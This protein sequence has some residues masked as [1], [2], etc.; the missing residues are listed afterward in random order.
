[1]PKTVAARGT[2]RFAAA[3]SRVEKWPCSAGGGTY[4]KDNVLAVRFLRMRLRAFGLNRPVHAVEGLVAVTT[5]SKSLVNL[6]PRHSRLHLRAH[7][8]A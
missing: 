2:L 3:Q 7:D 6:R 5:Q 4:P 1:M 8:S